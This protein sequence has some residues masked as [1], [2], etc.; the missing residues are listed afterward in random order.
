MA[1]WKTQIVGSKP[2]SWSAADF[3]SV[4]GRALV[5]GIGGGLAY[6]LT[7]FL[8]VVDSSAAGVVITVAGAALLDAAH[9]WMSDTR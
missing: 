2:W 5:V 9:K 3:R 4:G 6:F 8:P 1:D 7:R